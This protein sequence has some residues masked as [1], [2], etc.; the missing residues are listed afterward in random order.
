MRC[1]SDLTRLQDS[2]PEVSR[3]S[4]QRSTF[5]WPCSLLLALTMPALRAAGHRL[6]VQRERAAVEA[7]STTDRSLKGGSLLRVIPYIFSA[8]ILAVPFA[9]M[10]ARTRGNPKARGALRAL[11][12]LVVRKAWRGI[13]LFF[14]V[15]ALVSVV[16]DFSIWRIVAIWQLVGFFALAL[17]FFFLS[18]RSLRHCLREILVNVASGH[19][20]VCGRCAYPAAEGTRVCPECGGAYIDLSSLGI[21]AT[22]PHT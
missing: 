9:M 21:K 18:L 20:V 19:G 15:N 6:A 3:L 5:P 22:D 7:A 2:G 4:L 11:G 8:I 16:I 13:L 1:W 10:I 12:R 14:A 17:G